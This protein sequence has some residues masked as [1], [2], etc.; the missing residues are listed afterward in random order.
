MSTFDLY[1]ESGPKR[2]KTMVHILALLGCVA[3][4]P[5]T[6]EAVAATPAAIRAY[7]RLLHRQGEPVDPDAPFSTRVAEHITG[8]DWQ[9]NGSPYLTFD[10]DLEPVTADEVEIYLA[11]LR[12]MRETF[13]CWIE[14]QQP[15]D[16]DRV[17]PGHT[18]TPRRLVQHIVGGPGGYLSAAIG[19]ARGFSATAGAAERGQLPLPEALRRI[20]AMT[21]EAVRATTSEQRAAVIQ[22][23]RDIRTL[24]KGLRRALEHDWEHLLQLSR[25]PGGPAL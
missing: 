11:R 12:A 15:D 21:T 18:W 22:R 19:G 1:L 3:T 4:G 20:A 24:R 9:G 17:P 8:G 2:R 16:L 13:A 6:D 25:Y 5:T 10:F 7:L 23:P 14:A